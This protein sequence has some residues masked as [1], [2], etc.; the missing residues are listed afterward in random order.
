MNSKIEKDLMYKGVRCVV[1]GLK[2]GHRCG[3]VAIPTD[4]EKYSED[5]N[6]IDIECH[7][8]LT[9]GCVDNKYPVETK[10]P[11]AW[12]GFDCAHCWDK[13][14]IDLMRELGA[15]DKYIDMMTQMFEDPYAEVR[16]AEY[17]EEEC[18]RIVDQILE[19][20]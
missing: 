7:G 16:T 8:G 19:A 14:D 4:S 12:I 18:K 17:C 2:M 9:Y 1:L 20:E 5:Y 3:Y 10:T 11:T 13:R 15:D 6:S